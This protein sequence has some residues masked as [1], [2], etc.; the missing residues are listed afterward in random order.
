MSSGER[1]HSR[2]HL[3]EASAPQGVSRPGGSIARLQH[4]SPMRMISRRVPGLIHSATF[5]ARYRHRL[6][7]LVVRPFTSHPPTW[8]RYRTRRALRTASVTIR[9][10]PYGWYHRWSSPPLADGHN[11]RVCSLLSLRSFM[12]ATDLSAVLLGVLLAVLALRVFLV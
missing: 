1:C 7:L 4:L 12:S 2:S 10:S 5:A 11:D 9:I 6:Y 3:P 8:H